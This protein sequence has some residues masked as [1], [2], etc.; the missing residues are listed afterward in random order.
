[1][2]L[3]YYGEQSLTLYCCLFNAILNDSLN[4]NDNMGPNYPSFSPIESVLTYEAV[5]KGAG[6]RPTTSGGHFVMAPLFL[7]VCFPSPPPPP[8][9]SSCHAVLYWS[10]PHCLR[11]EPWWRSWSAS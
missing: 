2:S 9:S 3:L 7:F 10:V 4:S 11:K 1:M 8:S 6:S 5:R